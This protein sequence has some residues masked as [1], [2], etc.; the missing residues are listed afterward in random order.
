MEQ[1]EIVI[2]TVEKIIGTNVFVK[3]KDSN[4]PGTITLSEIAAGRIRNLRNYVVPKKIIVCKVLRI[5]PD[6]IELSLRRV[7]EKEKKEAMEE[8]TLEQTYR[9]IIKTIF[10][11]E[12]E[13]IIKEIEKKGNLKEILDKSKGDKKQLEKIIGKENSK[14]ILQILNNQKE[15]KIPIKKE[16]KLSSDDPNG[17]S[18]IKEAFGKLEDIEVKYLS[19][20]RYS[21]KTEGNSLKEGDKKLSEFLKKIESFAKEKGMNFGA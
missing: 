15:K 18:L 19:A 20:G 4:L 6:H 14:K 17:L 9:K 3:I 11:E 7:K 13:D 10:K 5:K 1:G 21:L 8:F 2:A 12:G 16:F